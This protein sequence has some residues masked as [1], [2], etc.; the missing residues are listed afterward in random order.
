MHWQPPAPEA[1]TIR[2]IDAYAANIDRTWRNPNLLIWHRNLWAIDH[3][4]SLVFQHAWPPVERWATRRY[5][6]SEHI[7]APV[8]DTLSAAELD[9][10]DAD[11]AARITPEQLGEVLALVPDDWLLSMNAAIGDDRDAAAWRL[12][13][14]EY[15]LAR[16]PER[17]NWRPELAPVSS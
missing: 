5:D 8:A 1:A 13:Y 7:L 4:A 17:T 14:Q 16:L 11:L 15:L 6:L 2:W 9:A 3:G 12:R 10:L